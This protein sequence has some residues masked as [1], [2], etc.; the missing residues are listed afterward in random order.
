[1]SAPLRKQATSIV[2]IVLAAAA[3]VY[4]W[5]WDRGSVT[6][7]ER[8][9]RSDNVLPAFRR[10]D[11][12]RIEIVHDAQAIVVEVALSDAGERTWLMTSPRRE[13]ANVAAVDALLTELASSARVRKVDGPAAGI[14]SPRARVTIAM[15]TVTWRIALGDPA[16]T[17]EG[18]AYA[19]VE[20]EPAVVVRAE[21]VRR[22]LAGA[23]AYRD[24]T[25]SPYASSEIATLAVRGPSAFAVE[26]ARSG[27]FVISGEGTRASQATLAKVWSAL[28]ELRAEQFL[29]DADGERLVLAPGYTIAMTARDGRRGEL[30]I[31]GA[32]PEHAEDVVVVRRAPGPLVAACAPKGALEGLAVSVDALRDRRLFAAGADEVTE[33]RLVGAR[34]LDLARAGSGW[35]L[36][37]PS[38]RTLVQDEIESVNALVLALTRS[39]GELVDRAEASKMRVAPSIEVT[40]MRAERG[41]ERV[42]VRARDASGVVVE[43]VADGAYVRISRATARLLEPRAV[44]V[45]ARGIWGA[46]LEGS[47]I[48]QVSARCGV[49]SDVVH[50][51]ASWRSGD[52]G[53]D[54]AATLDLANAVVRAK[55]DPWIADAD[56]GSFGLDGKCAVAV[57]VVHDGGTRRLA[58]LLGGDAD[59]N[60]VF[61]RVDGE[62]EVFVLPRALRDAAR[63]PLAE[64]G[65]AG[66]R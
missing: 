3:I 35:H 66:S 64:R 8:A 22:L 10:G 54:A 59:A 62:A 30:V 61:A 56:D 49:A 21:L 1:V 28:G 48:K 12:T 29:S 26:R 4:A 9:S 55:A 39:E 18:A 46:S 19:R 20:G 36:R 14:D 17:P 45:R 53:A 57:T 47:E 27:D 52:A 44:A 34:T 37:A 65:D 11:V 15:G 42:A 63:R 13:V 6:D 41:E 51:G 2:L 23:D 38:D 43:R 58:L 50:D 24:R 40:L 32:C 5:L 25:L 31:G 60:G 33:L 16:P 7:A